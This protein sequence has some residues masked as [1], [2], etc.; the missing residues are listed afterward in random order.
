LPLLLEIFVRPEATPL[1]KAAILES[2]PLDHGFADLK[3]RELRNAGDLLI[4]SAAMLGLAGLEKGRRNQLFK[5]ASRQG[6]H[7]A[8]LSS[9]ATRV[10]I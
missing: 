5:Y 3:E 8:M 4:L 2:R 9:I 7:A 1:V 6:A 10:T